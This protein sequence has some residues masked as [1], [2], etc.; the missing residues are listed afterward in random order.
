MTGDYTTNSHQRVDVDVLHG[1][2]GQKL[3]GVHHKWSISNFPC[4]LTRNITSHSM[5]NL[6]F[7]PYSDGIL[8]YQF[9]LH[10]FYMFP[11]KGWE[12][13]HFELGSGKRR[14]RTWRIFP[15]STITSRKKLSEERRKI[16]FPDFVFLIR[17]KQASC[18]SELPDRVITYPYLGYRIGTK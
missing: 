5:K 10:H 12:N 13:I 1:G 17:C 8:C 2:I 11:L 3:T 14:A 15:A 7:I 6:A 4:S 9:S 16:K 18:A